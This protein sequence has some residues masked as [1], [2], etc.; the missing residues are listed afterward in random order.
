MGLASAVAGLSDSGP[1]STVI[2]EMSEE[3]GTRAVPGE[4]A[5]VERAMAR[6]NIPYTLRL[7]YQTAINGISVQVANRH[8]DTIRSIPQVRHVWIMASAKVA[9]QANSTTTTTK[10]FA[11][12]M[13]GVD[14]VHQVHG[15]TGKGVRV[16]VIDTGIDY[17]HPALGGCFGKGCRVAYGW[18]FIGRRYADV[19]DPLEPHP[20]PRDICG[21]HGTHIAGIIGAREAGLVGVAPDVTFGAYRI[22]ACNGVLEGD[23][24]IGAMERA[25]HDHMDII[26]VSIYTGNTWEDNPRATTAERLTRRGVIA[27]GSRRRPA[28]APLAL[29]VA[30]VDNV[31][32]VPTAFQLDAPHRP[33]YTYA[34]LS[35]KPLFNLSAV[36][37]V[38]V[39]AGADDS[40]CRTVPMHSAGAAIL[41]S[42]AGC[43]VGQKADIAR[44]ARA[45]AVIVHGG[46]LDDAMAR[47]KHDDKRTSVPVVFVSEEDG[48]S[49]RKLLLSNP[50]FQAGVRASFNPNIPPTPN[51][52]G[53]QISSFSSWGP[54]PDLDIKPDV[55]APGG[56]IFSTYPLPMGAYT[57]MSGTS[58]STPYVVGAIALGLQR[59]GRSQYGAISYRQALRNTA[60]PIREAGTPGRHYTSVAKQGAGLINVERMIFGTTSVAPSRLALNDTEFGMRGGRASTHNLTIFNDSAEDR[61]FAIEHLPAMSVR[62]IGADGV[63]PN[64]PEQRD[65]PASMLTRSPKVY[66]KARAS[67]HV[68]IDIA[69]PA[70]LP[71]HEYWVYSGFVEI[72]PVA[73]ADG[74]PVA[75]ADLHRVSVPYLGVKGRMRDLHV[76]RITDQMPCLRPQQQGAA[77]QLANRPRTYTMQ[78]NDW[79]ELAFRLE[80]PSELVKIQLYNADTHQLLGAIPGFLTEQLGRH[81]LTD[82]NRQMS[83]VWPGIY[84]TL[85]AGSPATTKSAPDGRYY[86]K[87]MALRIFGNPKNER[88]YDIWQSPIITIKQ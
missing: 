4:Q 85:D 18:D 20:D 37:I 21:G 38:A 13:T 30:S 48:Q 2:I 63:V 52:T 36:N 10:P 12:S 69:E 74:K 84:T 57:V 17:S 78:N 71:A 40:G 67:A 76:M 79:P 46:E 80:M 33:V 61:V 31:A 56:S 55:A 42:Q 58:M 29:S 9:A 3:P 35:G 65:A 87:I 66:V 6:L 86:I 11:H 23:V 44:R 70:A 24:L 77:A 45:V 19:G 7:R 25:L 53:G 47:H 15:L 68:S 72:R 5:K 54:S 39:P 1:A 43:T 81:E 83:N 75:D 82:D 28:I 50:A 22:S 16:G 32:L 41:V 26:N 8:L 88:D 27:C 64:A 49:I 14:R 62:G 34:A 59:R 60:E 51:E 73:G